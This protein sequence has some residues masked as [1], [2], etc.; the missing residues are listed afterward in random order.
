MITKQSLSESANPNT[1]QTA[2]AQS[3]QIP[4]LFK[5]ILRSSFL[6][7]QEKLEFTSMIDLNLALKTHDRLQQKSLCEKYESIIRM[8]ST[9]LNLDATESL[10]KLSQKMETSIVGLIKSIQKLKESHE[11]T[12]KKMIADKR[13]VVM[14]V[15]QLEKKI[16]QY[17]EQELLKK[18]ST[19]QKVIQP[20]K[21]TM[22]EDEFTQI[23]RKK[24]DLILEQIQ[25]K[26]FTKLK[27]MALIL[28]IQSAIQVDSDIN[29]IDPMSSNYV[30]S[31]HVIQPEEVKLSSIGADKEF[32]YLKEFYSNFNEA[33][34]LRRSTSE[35]SRQKTGGYQSTSPESNRNIK[36]EFHIEREKIGR[37]QSMETMKQPREVDIKIKN[38]FSLKQF[39]QTVNSFQTK[40][41]AKFKKF[42]KKSLK[43]SNFDPETF[44]T[45]KI[46][47]LPDSIKFKFYQKSK[48]II[49]ILKMVNS[50]INNQCTHDT[51]KTDHGLQ[52]A[53]SSKEEIL[54]QKIGYYEQEIMLNERSKKVKELKQVNDCLLSEI[55][56]KEKTIEKLDYQLRFFNENTT[57]KNPARGESPK[58]DKTLTLL[59]D[60]IKHKDDTITKLKSSLEKADQENKKLSAQL[61][62]HLAKTKTDLLATMKEKGKSMLAVK[63]RNHGIYCCYSKSAN[64]KKIRIRSVFDFQ[65]VTQRGLF[66]K[67]V[68]SAS[69]TQIILNN[70]IDGKDIDARFTFGKKQKDLA[71]SRQEFENNMNRFRV[72]NSKSAKSF[73]NKINELYFQKIDNASK[74]IEDAEARTSTIQV[75]IESIRFIC[76]KMRFQAA[77]TEEMCR[78][79][80]IK[81]LQTQVK[82]NS[83]NDAKIL[84]TKQKLKQLKDKF[85]KVKLLFSEN[86]KTNNSLKSI[87]RLLEVEPSPNHLHQCLSKIKELKSDS[88]NM[89]FIK[90]QFNLS[91]NRECE[92]EELQRLK[93][94][95]ELVNSLESSF[96]ISLESENVNDIIRILIEDRQKSRMLDQVTSIIDT[97]VSPNDTSSC[98]KFLLMIMKIKT[99]IKQIETEVQNSF[100]NLS[101]KDID[102]FFSRYKSDR[103]LKSSETIDRV[104]K[105][106]IE[107]LKPT[108][109]DENNFIQWLTKFCEALSQKQIEDKKELQ[110]KEMENQKFI[111]RFIEMQTEIYN[112]KEQL[113]NKSKHLEQEKLKKVAESSQD[114]VK[115]DSLK[116]KIK[117]LQKNISD[118][119]K[120]LES[121]RSIIT[122][123]G[124]NTNDKDLKLK[125]EQK[126]N[127]FKKNPALIKYE[128]KDKRKPSNQ[129]NYNLENVR[130]IDFDD[131]REFGG[132]MASIYVSEH[133]TF[134]TEKGQLRDEIKDNSASERGTNKSQKRSYF[135]KSFLNLGGK[136]KI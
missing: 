96:K 69:S 51:N 60:N 28:D 10:E 132:E 112:L 62:E 4:L 88:S 120:K 20:V 100:L 102:D 84:K 38:D 22:D 39:D 65:I 118:L 55:D 97:N 101:S 73:L 110:S 91:S 63:K 92:I 99:I 41:I 115:N 94:A 136:S 18:I 126:M 128:F 113:D 29:V 17:E 125:F 59:R 25:K 48:L 68:L 76:Q 93:K 6:T 134:T 74:G 81:A 104:K 7:D 72:L 42:M 15:N 133:R 135:V 103:N 107:T 131:V 70:Q 129:K 1:N 35:F 90:N 75:N 31:R 127:E 2:Q 43:N 58:L 16:K 116:I 30:S 109:I 49:S 77:R 23:L 52:T 33:E 119:E 89:N 98:E 105:V 117:N 14:I 34:Y 87:C 80:I 71:H 45:S 40:I 11:A 121:C 64:S 54:R 61:N 44:L 9:K 27:L 56:R 8:V 86:Q 122:A 114:N 37:F 47:G 24:D 57:Q 50:K 19:S 26:R 95:E 78:K 82:I 66:E 5:K 3:G 108:F 46:Y 123:L 83:E 53:S 85:V 36:D 32:I 12:E 67:Q 79:A 106:I 13:K 111:D 124:L 130:E 21:E